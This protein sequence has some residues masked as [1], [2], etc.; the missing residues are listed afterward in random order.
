MKH[1][2]DSPLGKQIYSHRK[3]VVEPVFGNITTNKKLKRFSLRVK[4]KVQGKWQL[5][6]LKRN[7]KAE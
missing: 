7:I 3:S 1:P 2:V 5:F 4:E 6:C